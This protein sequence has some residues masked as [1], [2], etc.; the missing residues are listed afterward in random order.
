MF[1]KVRMKIN[2][3]SR[4]LLKLDVNFND[5]HFRNAK[6]QLSCLQSKLVIDDLYM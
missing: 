4:R 5:I 6:E 2:S 1:T 3:S